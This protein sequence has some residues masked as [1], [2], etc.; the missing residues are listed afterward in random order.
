[1]E[2][3]ILKHSK[4]RLKAGYVK[5][6]NCNST[7]GLVPIEPYQVQYQ[8]YLTLQAG[9]KDTF[10][11]ILFCR[12]SVYEIHL[13]QP[14]ILSITTHCY[15]FS[16]I[17]SA[18][19]IALTLSSHS[20]LFSFQLKYCS[21]ASFVSLNLQAYQYTYNQ[22]HHQSCKLFHSPHSQIE[23]LFPVCIPFNLVFYQY[24]K[25]S[26]SHLSSRSRGSTRP[27]S[28]FFFLTVFEGSSE[29]VCAQN[30]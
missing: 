28:S 5:P 7:T 30:M 25:Y 2:I 14:Y 11:T 26:F 29:V 13:L 16:F 18:L 1:M 8:L 27:F 4:F 10:Y 24:S 20:F 22:I 6:S 21:Y 15:L 23:H 12:P 9:I 17:S 3:C 19:F